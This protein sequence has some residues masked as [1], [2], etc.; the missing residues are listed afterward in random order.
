MKYNAVLRGLNEKKD[1]GG[2][3]GPMR[4]SFIELCKDNRYATTLHLINSAIV[5]LSKL[6]KVGKVRSCG[7]V[8]RSNRNFQVPRQGSRG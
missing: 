3:D 4:T 1:E 6:T 5:K 8:G 7:W 2:N